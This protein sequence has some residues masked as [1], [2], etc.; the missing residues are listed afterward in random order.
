MFVCFMC[1]FVGFAY[2]YH[3]LEYLCVCMGV[4]IWGVE[5]LSVCK[6]QYLL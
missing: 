2:V 4:C 5:V 1:V 6:N 3:G